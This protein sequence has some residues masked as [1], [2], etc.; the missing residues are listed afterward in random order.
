MEDKDA[1][2]VFDLTPLATA[3]WGDDD[4]FTVDSASQYKFQLKVRVYV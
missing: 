1:G 2:Y 4:F 3:K